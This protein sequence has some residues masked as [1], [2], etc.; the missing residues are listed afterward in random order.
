ML[1][2]FLH[3][4]A[5]A[6]N[7]ELYRII[8]EVDVDIASGERKRYFPSLL[9]LRPYNVVVY[10]DTLLSARLSPFSHITSGYLYHKICRK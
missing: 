5:I 4:R 9:L 3:K 1:L 2:C 8:Q 7:K 6:C 10:I